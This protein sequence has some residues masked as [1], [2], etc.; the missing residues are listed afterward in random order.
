MIEHLYIYIYIYIRLH[1]TV[2][3]LWYIYIYISKIK[4]ATV[5]KGDQKAPFSVA[6]ILR[7]RG[8]HYSFPWITP[9]YPR[10]V[11]YI[12]SVKQGAIKY[13]F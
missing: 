3:D 8:G 5:D 13:H 12:M 4:L 9:L 11:P 2:F 6:T 7:C 10:Y 1:G